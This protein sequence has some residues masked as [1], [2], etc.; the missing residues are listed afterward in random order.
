LRDGSTARLRPV[1]SGDEDCLREF[2]SRLD[3]YSQAFRFFSGAADLG[4][5]AHA[6]ANVDYAGR[7]G[8]LASHGLGGRL[9]GHG[10]YAEL[11]DGRA[12]VAFAI[13]EEMQGRGLGT[14]LL[15]HLAE[16]AAENGI[17]TFAAEVLP[18]NHQMVEM[19]QERDF[20]VE[21]RTEPDTLCVELPTALSD[22]AIA[23]F[24]DRDRIAA[25][26]AVRAFLEPR[27]VAVVGASRQP[28]RVG[29]A[30]LRN[31]LACG[32]P[33]ELYAVN[34]AAGEVEGIPT[35]P[36]VEGIGAEIDLAVVAVPAGK[37]LAVARE[38]AA[39]GVRALIVLSAGFA[40]SGPEGVSRERELLGICR[41]AGMRLIGPNCLGVLGTDPRHP[42]DATF[43]PGVPP[44]GDVGFATQSGA[45]GLALIDLAA[46]KGVGVS[47]FASVGNRADIT[48]NDL[49]EFWEQD[50]RTRVA[51][52]YLESFSDPRRFARISRRIGPKKPIVAVKS[53]RSGSGAR[54]AGS[55]TGAL[56]AASDRAT[57]A[58]F[59]QSGV[60][61]AETLAE[62]LDVASLL[63]SQPLPRGPRVGILTNA[64]GPGIMCADACEAAGLEVPELAPEVREELRAFLPS[65]A[66]LGNP[67]DM[68]ATAEAE[69]FRRAI[70]ALAGWDGIDALIVIFIRPLLT[71][72]ADVAAAVHEAVADL[73]RELPV[74]AVFMSP[75]DHAT[76]QRE[77]TVPSYLYPEDAARALGK[78]HGH[79]RWR[80]RPRLPAPAPGDVREAEAAAILAEALGEAR[81]WLEPERCERLLDAYGITTPQ[82]RMAIDPEAAG[83]AAT[84]IGG[85]VAL[86]AVGP[87]IRHKTEIGAVRLG[88]TGAA[89]VAGAAREIDAE[90]ARRGLAREAFQVQSAIADGVEM[91]VGIAT[92]PVLGAVIAC[93]AGGTA[94]EL[95]GDVQL[96]VSPLDS[97]DPSE[98]LDGL[99]VRP[100]LSGYRGADPVD[101]A[102]LE[103]VIARV[104]ALARS[105]PEI[106]ELDLNPV[107]A[108]PAGAIAVDSRVRLQAMR[109]QLPWP[110]TWD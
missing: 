41:E 40:E 45:L 109:P 78:V 89:Q 60:I 83:R 100:L 70:A 46:T 74:Q 105:H 30:V 32:F 49:L 8:L 64:G 18:S 29:N 87:E 69:H 26:E 11:G 110:R 24:E 57:D 38:C 28:G 16:A 22:E 25:V 82:S 93:G 76:L 39:K 68:I 61:R 65:E 3:P 51:L 33:G 67:V 92:D 59:E 102:A 53:G 58:L 71:A 34:P 7:Y 6:L 50:P 31:L 81:E 75:E 66:A 79:V 91:I 63:S 107:L 54:A 106:V 35:A 77:A 21:I 96:R 86:K 95:L 4:R 43:A 72:A 97:T 47:S 56:L 17:E 84:E 14:I 80:Q 36:S 99:A 5:I 73:P 9:V 48:P 37:V 52:L 13:A 101:L 15:A 98:M 88:L 10:V 19:L 1:R 23:R 12:E 94:V 103:D 27:S 90:L 44:P 104:D 55:H 42:L 108:T 2:L 85:T 62:L 20:P